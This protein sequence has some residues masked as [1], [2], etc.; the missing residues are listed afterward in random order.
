M[1]HFPRISGGHTDL[2]VKG[3]FRIHGGI[4]RWGADG[5]FPGG[6]SAHLSKNITS[7]HK[8]KAVS[9]QRCRAESRTVGKA[10]KFQRLLS[11]QVLKNCLQV[12]PS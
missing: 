5:L 11:K 4:V 1:S 8:P 3:E 2:T 6:E 12:G 9:R 10:R 7:H